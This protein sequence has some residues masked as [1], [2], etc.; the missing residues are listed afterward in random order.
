MA[1]RDRYISQCSFWPYASSMAASS[2]G[3]CLPFFDEA[4]LDAPA[5]HLDAPRL[6]TLQA[7]VI[8]TFH[9]D[10]VANM[11]TRSACSLRKFWMMACPPLEQVVVSHNPAILEIG[12]PRGSVDGPSSRIDPVIA[13]FTLCNPGIQN[14]VY[15]PVLTRFHIGDPSEKLDLEGIAWWSPACICPICMDARASKPLLSSEEDPPWTRKYTGSD[16]G[17]RAA[18]LEV[19]IKPDDWDPARSRIRGRLHRYI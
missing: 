18:G 10:R 1:S 7:L 4:D 9:F 5:I 12:I 19:E 8:Q 13:A 15:T 17:F 11:L 2:R 6:P 16:R 14:P 3:C